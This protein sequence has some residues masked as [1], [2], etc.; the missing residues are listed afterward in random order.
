MEERQYTLWCDANDGGIK[1]GDRSDTGDLQARPTKGV[2]RGGSGVPGGAGGSGGHVT[3]APDALSEAVDEGVIEEEDIVEEAAPDELE[4]RS[5]QDP[6][7]GITE[8]AGRPPEDWAADTGPAHN[9]EEGSSEIE[10]L[11]DEPQKT[12]KPVAKAAAKRRK[13]RRK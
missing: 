3:G 12:P 13:A 7:L 11:P 8:I 10:E 6:S 5:G 1:R 2:G 9:P 4:V